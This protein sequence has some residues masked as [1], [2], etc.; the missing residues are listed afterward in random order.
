MRDHN[1]FVYL[2][3]SKPRGTLYVGVTNDLLRRI[4]DH[5]A[6]AIP[7]FTKKYGIKLLVWFERHGDIHTAIAREK[8]LKKWRRDWKY[9]LI[10]EGNRL[11]I[12]LYPALAGRGSRTSQPSHGDDCSSGMTG[13]A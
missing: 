3:A 9:N 12:D 10:E 4:T 5:R 8:Q 1:Y 13:K 2:L 6:G 11:W 7:G